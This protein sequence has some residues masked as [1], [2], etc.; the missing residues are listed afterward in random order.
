MEESKRLVCSSSTFL[1]SLF[2]I[3]P[4]VYCAFF[5]ID[6]WKENLTNWDGNSST[7]KKINE[8]V[9]EQEP[10]NSLLRRLVR[11]DQR[12]QL[13]D[14]GFAYLSELHSD[15]YIAS[16]EVRFDT[17]A[18]KIYIN[19]SQ[20]LETY[21]VRPY[22][23]KG[24]ETGMN[25]VAPIEIQVGNITP[26]A[27]DYI[28][29]VSAIVF[30]SGGF[31]G[32]VFHEIND[33]IIPLF[34]TTRHFRSDVKFM[35]TDFQPWFIN[36]YEK[37]FTRLSRHG[38]INA[39][40]IANGTVHCFPGAV[41][42]LKYHGYLALNMS[43]IPGG[44]SM[45]DFRDFLMKSYKFKIKDVSQLIKL[46][47]KPKLLLLS[48]MKT[49]TLVNQDEVV[50]MMEE[51][52]FQVVIVTPDMMSYFDE[53]AHM[54]NSFSVMVGVHG[55]GLTNELFLPNEAVM[56]QVVPLALDWPGNAY[57]G[58]P[59]KRMGLQYLEY[60]IELEE[61]TLYDLYPSDHPVIA[62][63]ESIKLQGYQA[64]RAIYLDKQ[65]VKINVAR[66]RKTL[67]EAIRLLGR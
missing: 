17:N 52:G 8:D 58:A 54:V 33:V 10:L 48:R 55:A 56:I 40:E 43:D 37:I 9:Q 38:V 36:K 22:A 2:I 35:I 42:G 50:K 13:E 15:I 41:V 25:L 51:L 27:C 45:F 5:Q 44:Y 21:K 30:S 65:N 26:P 67:I 6:R 23:L 3:L 34:I 1:I 11:G 29:D 60:K 20:A 49:R 12:I 47:E 7:G 16:K 32:N 28:H 66:F 4:L 57:Y 18:S 59:A 24:D 62:D 64:F 31:V 53:F 14:N 63:P 19:T 61:S 46:N 39:A